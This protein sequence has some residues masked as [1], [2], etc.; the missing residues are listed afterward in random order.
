MM[1]KGHEEGWGFL[2][3][4]AIDQH[5]VARKRENDLAE[6]I[7]AH[8][9]LLG[10]GI[11]EATAIVVTANR[12]RVIGASR[13]VIHDKNYRPAEGPRYYLLSPGEEFDLSKRCKV[14]VEEK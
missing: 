2:K 3:A 7:D 1:A 13:V 4:A 6:V 8:P 5:V 11:D 12:F 9:E 10:I 14:A